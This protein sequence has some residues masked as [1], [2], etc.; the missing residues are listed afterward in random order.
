[1][2]AARSP[3]FR[4]R[5]GTCSDDPVADLERGYANLTMEAVATRA[6]TSR[7]VL[8]RRWSDK[9]DLVHSALTDTLGR[10]R[11]TAPDTGSLRDDVLR[12][13]MLIHMQPAADAAIEEIVDT[14]VLPLISIERPATGP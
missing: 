2:V 5:L 9:N 4:R 13:E 11:P 12:Q 3:I 14:I 1:M 8:S 7:P 10:H 6:G